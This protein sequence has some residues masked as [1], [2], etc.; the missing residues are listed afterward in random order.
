MP[1]I[2]VDVPEELATNYDALEAI[3]RALLEDFV[4][5][6]R[7]QLSEPLRPGVAQGQHRC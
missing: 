2:T 4:T 7:K 3:R 6:R 5:M 1:A